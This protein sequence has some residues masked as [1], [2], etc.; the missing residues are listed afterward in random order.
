[1]NRGSAFV[2]SLLLM[3]GMSV[4]SV[5][6]VATEVS[7]I[8]GD[9]RC[10]SYV[11]FVA[12]ECATGAVITLNGKGFL[13]NKDLITVSFVGISSLPGTGSSLTNLP[14]F[15]ISAVQSLVNSG[16]C[17][18]G[19]QI[20]GTLSWGD[21][22]IGDFS[23]T[24]N[25]QGT[26]TDCF[27]TK[28]GTG[29]RITVGRPQITSVIAPSPCVSSTPFMNCSTG[30]FTIIGNYFDATN[31]SYSAVVFTSSI[32]TSFTAPT[33]TIDANSFTSSKIVCQI[34]SLPG[35]VDEIVWLMN[36]VSKGLQSNGITIM[37]NHPVP[38][39][40]SVVLPT[41]ISTNP[42]QLTSCTTGTMTITGQNFHPNA[43]RNFVDFSS[44]TPGM[45]NPVCDM[46]FASTTIIRCTFFGGV[47]SRTR[48]SIRLI[49]GVGISSFSD[50]TIDVAGDAPVINSLSFTPACTSSNTQLRTADGCQSGLLSILGLGFNPTR[51]INAITLLA[52]SGTGPAPTCTILESTFRSTLCQFTV[53]PAT[54]GTW[55]MFYSIS[56]PASQSNSPFTL[57]VQ[58]LLP[59]VTSIV[60][61]PNCVS[62][63]A[64]SISSCGV[65]S[66]ITF[67]GS[68]FVKEYPSNHLINFTGIVVSS[69]APYCR[70][71]VVTDGSIECVLQWDGLSVGQFSPSLSVFGIPTA[72]PSMTVSCVPPEAITFASS[73]FVYQGVRGSTISVTINVVDS[74]GTIST[75]SNDQWISWNVDGFGIS[76]TAT[77]VRGVATIAITFGASAPDLTTVTFTA[78][79]KKTKTLT[80]I[81]RDFTVST[82]SQLSIRMTFDIAIEKFT[83]ADFKSQIGA[84]MGIPATRIDVVTYSA[85]STIV[86]W[87]VL[88]I[89]GTTVDTS[90]TLS[91]VAN[92]ATYSTALSAST[93]KPLGNPVLMQGNTPTPTPYNRSTVVAAWMWL[94][95]AVCITISILAVITYGVHRYILYRD[96]YYKLVKAPSSRLPMGPPA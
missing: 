62:L 11:G 96:E 54:Q 8:T 20:V 36:V 71:Q 25:Q 16:V 64:N 69:V 81:K 87:R 55:N 29:P 91:F 44:S 59:S 1:M 76:Y 34:A 78:I 19:N 63:S 89:T 73:S 12:A 92:Y 31:P 9:S 37:F 35:G 72:L 7:F 42:K 65:D 2:L 49:I 48:F 51:T 43:A 84:V 94:V 24:V 40:E 18:T 58:S 26:A 47:F 85:G 61:N 38:I 93:L 15:R 57:T 70:T 50:T 14:T 21:G 95:G 46:A 86:Y 41:C 30:V 79:V 17:S 66:T 22:V 67:L 83:P 80:S 74:F 68:N 88:D 52:K 32:T 13:S 60:P 77:T 53:R 39:I 56:N 75:L 3:L 6:S 45:V 23:L 10:S 5:Y 4:H 82:P 27:D 33:C 28:T 90:S